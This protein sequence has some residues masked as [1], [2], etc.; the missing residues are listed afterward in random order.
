MNLGSKFVY[1]PPT[2]KEEVE[3][4]EEEEIIYG[5]AHVTKERYIAQD[6]GE[7]C[8]LDILDT[9]GQEE[10]SCMRD[11]YVRTGEGFYIVYSITSRSSFDEI[12]SIV[13]QIRR[14]KD[15]DDV[16]CI[17]VGNKTDRE[18]DRQV[19]TQEGKDLAR[20][21]NILF[22][23]T[24]ATDYYSIENAF[25]TLVRN[26][27]RCG[28]EYKI[29]VMG[30]GGVGKSASVMQFNH[31]HFIDEYDPTIE[32]SYRKQV[33]ISGLPRPNN[34]SNP[35]VNHKKKGKS[36][37]KAC[38]K[39][40]KTSIKTSTNQQNELKKETYTTTVR[41]E[42]KKKKVIHFPKESTNCLLV[43]LGSLG[44]IKNKKKSKE[45]LNYCSGC[46]VI[47]SSISTIEKTEIKEYKTEEG[48]PNND[49]LYNWKCEFCGTLNKNIKINSIP[50]KSSNLFELKEGIKQQ[51]K[52]KKQTKQTIDT[53]DGVVI[54]CIDVSGSMETADPIPEFQKQWKLAQ[55]EVIQK[56]TRLE[57]MKTAVSTHI[58]R[59]SVS[60]PNKKVVIVTFHSNVTIQCVNQSLLV[61]KIEINQAKCD[62]N[63]NIVQANFSWNEIPSVSS[64]ESTLLNLVDSI[65]SQGS[66][67]LGPGLLTCIQM[68][69][70]SGFPSEIIVCTD[71]QPN[72]G[73]GSSSTLNASTYE[74]IGSLALQ[75]EAKVSLIGIENCK[76]A[77]E[78]LSECASRTGGNISILHPIEIVREIRKISQDNTVARDVQ[79]SVILHP[80]L[81]IEK[82]DCSKGLSRLVNE[83][84]SVSNLSEFTIE[85]S[86]RP[87]VVSK[88]NKNSNLIP[89][90]YPFQ[91]QFEFTDRFGARMKYVVSKKAR[92]TSNRKKAEQNC[93]V[94]VVAQSGIHHVGKLAHTKQYDCSLRK[95]HCVR[96]LL[97]RGAISDEQQ[98]EF[99]MFVQRSEEF[100]PILKTTNG[101]CV[102]DG[103]AR[104]IY[105]MQKVDS[106]LF[107]STKKKKD[108]IK[109]RQG[110]KELNEQYYSYKF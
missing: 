53:S 66:T 9:A 30:G 86:V 3:K 74:K 36:F 90:F 110:N 59:M 37:F 44:N 92:I 48:K 88:F 70:D 98:E 45:D 42:E 102:S 103:V 34:G 108:I 22:T 79:V 94:A 56:L 77:M 78:Y 4:F 58:K 62:F 35:N 29:V 23:E 81:M 31:H 64:S 57:A 32:D 80:D 72:I 106:S 18:C 19:T 91:C 50:K 38:K 68:A 13:D 7:T 2:K 47:L 39:S 54:F 28:K 51:K 41:T 49:D 61:Q 27:P 76:C 63:L 33:T 95:L 83:F 69:R 60:M 15:L 71:G 82:L 17:M 11:Q 99:G 5:V 75:S 107:I 85:Y 97:E 20:S 24:S 101:N 89:S 105:Q 21:L 109:R 65:R 87:R 73:I 16:P 93:N 84:K 8:L 10:Y 43:E 100:E 14:V 6:D 25:F 40:S 12:S 67:A 1:V 104:A 46:N 96:R 55:G 26:I 52:N